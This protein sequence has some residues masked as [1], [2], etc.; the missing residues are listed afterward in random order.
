MASVF[1]RWKARGAAG[2]AAADRPHESRQGRA[3]VLGASMP[4]NHGTRPKA[5][6]GRPCTVSPVGVGQKPAWQKPTGKIRLA[7]RPAVRSRRRGICHGQIS[8]DV[9]MLPEGPNVRD[10]RHMLTPTDVPFQTLAEREVNETDTRAPGKLS[11]REE[12]EPRFDSRVELCG[13]PRSS[14]ARTSASMSGMETWR[15]HVCRCNG[16]RSPVGFGTPQRGAGCVTSRPFARA[17]ILT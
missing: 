9:C 7:K 15:R 10:G 1:C 11:P 8:G 16:E 2:A 5:P 12:T 3:C 14:S 4:I 13:V 6:Q 17:T